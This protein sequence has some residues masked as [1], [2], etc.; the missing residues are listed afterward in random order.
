MPLTMSS[1]M[2]STMFY[3]DGK[4]VSAEEFI[5]KLFDTLKLPEILGSEDNLRELWSNPLT[6]SE[7]IR[8][9]E[10]HGCSKDDLKDI[11]LLEKLNSFPN[12]IEKSVTPTPYFFAK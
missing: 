8:K 2:S 11:K 3:L 12:P 10:N 4:P 6:R 9:L 1:T 7:L 5:K